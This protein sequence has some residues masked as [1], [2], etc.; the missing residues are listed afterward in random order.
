M[1]DPFWKKVLRG[2]PE[3]CW[4]WTGYT[5]PSGHGLT[6]YKSEPIHASRKAYILTHGPFD[7]RLCVLHT[8]DNAVCCNPKHLY[9]GTR[10]DNMIDRFGNIAPEFRKATG[11]NRVLTDAQIEEL[12]EMRRNRVPLREC[13]KKF[14]IH[15]GTI[16]RYLTPALKQKLENLRAD[17]LGTPRTN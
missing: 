8:C 9:L 10:M 16:C 14:G 17:R 1:T 6:T 2:A 15:I 3:V 4:P 13:A 12:W 7:L 5:K 11:R